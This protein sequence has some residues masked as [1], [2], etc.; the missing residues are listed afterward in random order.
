MNEGH[1]DRPTPTVPP[2]EAEKAAHRLAA[3][4]TL[5]GS[6][7][8]MELPTRGMSMRPLIGPDAVAEIKFVPV[9]QV[10]V[11][12]VILF[13]REDATVLH[14][15]MAKVGEGERLTLV[16]KGD[17][18][19]FSSTITG[20]QYLGLMT[21]LKTGDRYIDF[22]TKQGRLQARMLVLV[23]RLEM[24]LYRLKV[25]VLGRQPTR[26]GRGLNR[27]LRQARSGLLRLLPGRG[28]RAG[29]QG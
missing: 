11:G 26:W 18:Q 28:P 7:K 22:Q 13:L 25:A 27:L 2:A 21:G 5:R 19:P 20:A 16:E 24:H 8:S 14:R 10:R 9:D 12:D 15:V 4:Q 29:G 1:Q 23:S 6:G 17:H 3:L